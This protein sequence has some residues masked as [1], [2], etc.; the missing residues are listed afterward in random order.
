MA[1]SIHKWL[2]IGAVT[3]CCE[4][5]NQF[6]SPIFLTPKNDGSSRFILNLKFLNKFII[7]HHFKME[8][9]RTATQ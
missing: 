3:T 8:D 4:T 7:Q 5:P 6:I 9:I 1:N 2:Q